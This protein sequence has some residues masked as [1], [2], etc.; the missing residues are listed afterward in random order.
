ML[1]RRLLLSPTTWTRHLQCLSL[2]RLEWVSIRFKNWPPPAL[3]SFKQ[4]QE[5][6]KKVSGQPRITHRNKRGVI[7][8]W[9][10]HLYLHVT[11]LY[12]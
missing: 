11:L 4:G 8:L 5:S 12:E 1:K 9:E 6:S 3:L 2:Q 10:D 7:K